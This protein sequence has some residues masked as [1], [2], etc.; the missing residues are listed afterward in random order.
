MNFFL[1]VTCHNALLECIEVV[2]LHSKE[3]HLNQYLLSEPL[4][5]K[6]VD[7]TEN[8]CILSKSEK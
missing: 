4:T 8:A 5:V 7:V 2:A 1:Q 3:T 6:P